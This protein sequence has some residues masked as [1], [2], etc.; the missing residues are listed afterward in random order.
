MAVEVSNWEILQWYLML[1]MFGLII[2]E[3]FSIIE[4][5]KRVAKLMQDKREGK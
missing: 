5:H 2:V 3:A 4:L 1:C